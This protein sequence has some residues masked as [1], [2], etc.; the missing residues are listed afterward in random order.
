MRWMTSTTKHLFAL[1]VIILLSSVAGVYADWVYA[2]RPCDDTVASTN[3]ILSDFVWAPEEILPTE[4]PG[5]NYMDLLESIL[6]NTKGGLNSN[7]DTLENAVLRYDL[8]HSSQNVQGGNLKH[9]FITEES[10]ELDFLVQYVADE[11][12]HVYIFEKDDVE[13]GS[14]NR[15]NIKVYKTILVVENGKWIGLESQLGYAL[16]RYVKGNQYIAVD[17]TEWQKG[18]LPTA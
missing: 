10:R 8:V 6:N 5:E 1:T 9:L 14:V 13:N 15:T 16:L 3:V 18:Y 12:F 4:T 17:P 7:K 11:E 2:L